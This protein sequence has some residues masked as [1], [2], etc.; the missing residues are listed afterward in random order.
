MNSLSY[1]PGNATRGQRNKDA[2]AQYH[3]RHT[4]SKGQ[5]KTVSKWVKGLAVDVLANMDK[6]AMISRTVMSRS[7]LYLHLIFKQ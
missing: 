1:E 5:N 3:N 2:I 7:L 4:I 6:L